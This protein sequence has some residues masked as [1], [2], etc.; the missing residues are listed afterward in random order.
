[1]TDKKQNLESRSQSQDECEVNGIIYNI[2]INLEKRI[3]DEW[4][5]WM[6]Q[7]YAPK[8]IAT[9]CFIRYSVLKLLDHDDEQSMTYVVQYFS[10]N[11]NDY[12]YYIAEFDEKFRKESFDKWGNKFMAFRTVLQVVH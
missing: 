6:M 10:L 3:A 5:Q 8:I 11:K 9:G 7:V 4:L 1:M 2:T 12:Q